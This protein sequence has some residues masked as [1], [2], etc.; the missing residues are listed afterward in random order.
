MSKSN[1]TICAPFRNSRKSLPRLIEQV[2]ALDYPPEQLRVIAVEGDSTDTTATWL[3]TWAENDDRVTLLTCN[4]GK[5]H[6]PSIVNAERFAAL[7]QVFNTALDAV[8]YEWSDYVL[9]TPSDVLF[10]PDVL[11]RLLAHGKDMI[12]PFFYGDGRF[13]DT[14]AFSRNGQFFGNFPQSKAL[15]RY[16]DAPIEMETVGGM[17][18]IHADVLRAGCRYTAAEVDRGLCK[19]ARANGF[20]VWAD[21]ATYIVH[22]A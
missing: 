16:G 19:A 13:R 4:T 22:G 7:A 2:S 6:Y 8:D 18:L 9:F 1:V 20:G 11:S 14:W 10:A 12:A 21:P 17:V 3:Q 15:A 5:R